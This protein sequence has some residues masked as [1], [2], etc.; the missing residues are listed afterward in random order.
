[1]GMFKLTAAAL[2]ITVL[3]LVGPV[4]YA[5]QA[6]PVTTPCSPQPGDPCQPGDYDSCWNDDGIPVDCSVL[7][8]DQYPAPAVDDPPVVLAS[9]TTA[10]TVQPY[11]PTAADLNDIPADPTPI[12]PA[13]T[14]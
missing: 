2:T 6:P 13:F 12:D 10:P 8:P 5:A 1:M 7:Y 9:E 14:G 11:Q 3:S 4:A